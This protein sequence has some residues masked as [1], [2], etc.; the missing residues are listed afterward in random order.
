MILFDVVVV[1]EMATFIRRSEL[2]SKRILNGPPLQTSL[3]DYKGMLMAES[4]F[5]S[6][7]TG[8]NSLMQPS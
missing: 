5:I 4:E 3:H 1:L 7:T 8:I 2:V 6:K